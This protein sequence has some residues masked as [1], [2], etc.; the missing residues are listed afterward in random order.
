MQNRYL[1]AKPEAGLAAWEIQQCIAESLREYRNARRVLL[2]PPDISRSNAYAGPIVGFLRAFF[3]SADIDLLPALGT[4]TPMTRAEVESMYGDFPLARVHAHDWRTGTV[5]LGTVDGAHIS[6]ISSGLL[7]A[8]IDVEIN[9][10]LFDPDYDLIVSIGQVVP[11]EVAGFANYTKN[12]LVGCGGLGMINGSHYLGAMYGMERLMGRAKNPV[13]ELYNSAASRFLSGLPLAYILT[14]TTMAATGLRVEGVS[15]GQGDELFFETAKLS[16]A[17]NIT[18]LPEPI[19]KAVVYLD[20]TKFRTTWVGNKA[21]YRTRMALAD[22][23]KLV[24]IAPGL[25]GCGEDAHNDTLIKQYGY[26]PAQEVTAAVRQDPDLAENLAV[27]AHLIHGSSDGRFGVTYAPGQMKEEGIRSLGY[28]YM[29]LETALAQYDIAKLRDGFNDVRG[30]RIFFIRNP[31][32]GLWTTADK[33]N[34]LEER[35]GACC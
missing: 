10:R 30:E 28:E 27:A 13:R 3:H 17:K 35:G 7:D 16:R 6:S 34:S 20:E 9:S 19:E 15:I 22:G 12:V 4:H 26:R 5:K 29:P 11:H 25:H 32:L 24:I 8:S 33:Y 1:T 14:V 21:I 18:V 2:V 31:A 23:G